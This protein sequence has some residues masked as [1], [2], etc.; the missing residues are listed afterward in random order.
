MNLDKIE[1]SDT[2][3]HDLQYLGITLLI[4][5]I[6]VA[7]H[8]LVTPDEPLR[9]GMVELETRCVGV[10]VGACIGVQRRTHK[11]FNYDDYSEI[12][13]GTPNLYRK[14]EAELMARAYNVCSN[15]M[16]GYDWTSEV[17]YRGKTAEQWRQMEQVELLPCEKTLF[18]DMTED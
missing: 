13:P 16:S 17:S 4:A 8:N 11:T 1:P 6:A 9:V 7:G 12:E 5:V 10:D 2:F 3:L 15:E 18:R 14:V